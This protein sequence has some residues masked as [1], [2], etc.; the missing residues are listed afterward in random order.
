MECYGLSGHGREWIRI[1]LE[2][3][4]QGNSWIPYSNWTSSHQH[5]KH[6]AFMNLVVFPLK[7]S[8]VFGLNAHE[9]LTILGT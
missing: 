2:E 6:Y 1:E 9:A 7:R 8:V 4:V 5:L 3:A